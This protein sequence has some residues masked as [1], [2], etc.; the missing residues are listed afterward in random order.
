[1]PD[2]SNSSS[3]TRPR[4]SSRSG[5]GSLASTRP[6][7]CRHSPSTGFSSGQAVGRNRSS[8]PSSAASAR[9]G[10][11]RV[12]A[13]AVEEQDDVPPP[14]DGPDVPQV[15]LE[16]ALVPLRGLVQ[17]QRPGGRVERP[18]QD[19]LVPIPGDRD[20]GLLADRRPARPQGRGLGQ[21]GGVG[22]QH[23]RPFP[24]LQSGLEPPFACRQCS[25]RRDRTNRGRFHRYPSRCSARRTVASDA[26]TPFRRQ[27]GEQQRGGPGRVPVP[28]VGRGTRH[29]LRQGLRDGVP[30]VGRAAA[31]A[32]VPEPV[33]PGAVGVPPPGGPLI[34]GGPADPVSLG[35]SGRGLP[36]VQVEQGQRPP[37]LPGVGAG[38]GLLG[39]RLPVPGGQPECHHGCPSPARA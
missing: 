1:M 6:L 16:R 27:V 13:P 18:V 12:R 34:D 29:Q 21:D 17:P 10:L 4:L 19:G 11:G 30:G 20:L 5:V 3:H 7:A 35:H 2:I 9:A 32:G 26:A 33:G 39:Q 14:P 23:H 31:P 28:V 25:A 15:V 22:E 36:G 38:P 37:G 24:V 8:T